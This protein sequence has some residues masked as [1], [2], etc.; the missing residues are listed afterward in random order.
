MQ[1]IGA[2]GI[3]LL[4]R[5]KLLEP[6]VEQELIASLLAGVEL[7]EDSKTAAQQSYLRQHGAYSALELPGLIAASGMTEDE[8]YAELYR[9]LRMAQ[10]AKEEFG[11]KAES[12][13]LQQK[14]R[15]DRVVYSLLRLEN[16]SQAQELYLRIA[17]AEASFSDLAARYSQGNERNTNGVVGPVP[18]NQSHPTLSDKLQASQPGELLEPFQVD[19]WWVVARLERFAPAV[20][21]QR[22][23]MQ[24]SMELLQEWVK[25]ESSRTFQTLL[26]QLNGAV[27]S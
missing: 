19:R 27:S 26:Q 24:M 3:H 21:D 11:A 1:V 5:H 10:L 12:R 13:F 9:P 16:P 23:D 2:H 20:F 7:P 8:F 22:M 14:S 17:N 18:L 25:Q 4:Q 6:L 15:L